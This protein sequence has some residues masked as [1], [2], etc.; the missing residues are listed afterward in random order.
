[1][2]LG[3]D[4]VIAGTLFAQ[5]IARWGNFFNQEL[6]GPPTNLP[7][8]IV[9][10]CAHRV[11]QY[12]C[13]LYPF[14]TT[15]FHP[16]F[17]Y[18]SALDILGGLI[19]LFISRRYLARI[20]PGD[21]VAFW[22][23]WYGT[24]RGLL[25]FFREGWNWTVSGIPTAQLIGI[26]VFLIGV[27]W[28]AYNHRPGTRPFDYPPPILPLPP[29][30]DPFADDAPDP[31]ADDEEE[32]DDF[33]DDDDDAADVDDEADEAEDDDDGATEGAEDADDKPA[34]S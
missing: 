30:P 13:S 8:G 29:P 6:Y 31:F 12:P 4:S 19:V 16:L 1:M 34:S 7:W 18:E 32:T 27:V 23:I 25:E 14:E 28:I 11:A 20:Q 21:L 2:R 17:F 33:D 22:G 24:T 10:D 3:L 15:G 26:M 9:I 5:G